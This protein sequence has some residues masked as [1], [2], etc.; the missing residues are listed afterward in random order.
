MDPNETLAYFVSRRAA[1][2]DAIS[3]IVEIESP[4]NDPAGSIAVVDWIE[5]RF[6]ELPLDL[7][8]ERIQAE[9][10]GTH[11]IVRAFPGDSRPIMLLGHTDT[12]H[13]RGTKDQN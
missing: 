7:T 1:M 10:V 11:L 12:V 3:E 6:R 9:G 4:P 8:F 13:A 5:A 2:V